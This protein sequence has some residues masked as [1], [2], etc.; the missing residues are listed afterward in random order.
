LCQSKEQPAE[1]KFAERIEDGLR[2]SWQTA[3]DKRDRTVQALWF[4]VAGLLFI[5]ILT[6]SALLGAPGEASS[7]AMRVQAGID[8]PIVC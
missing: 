3:R 1:G 5:W 6:V 8:K 4:L 7:A 2:A